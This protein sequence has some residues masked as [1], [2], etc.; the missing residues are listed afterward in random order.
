VNPRIYEKRIDAAAY[1]RQR[2]K[3]R[4][5]SMLL[6]MQLDEARIEELDLDALL[7]FAEH[8]LTNA[9][10]LWSE[11]HRQRLQCVFFPEGLQFAG[12]KFRTAVTCLAFRECRRIP[13]QKMV[14]RPQGDSQ[15]WTPG[16]WAG[17]CGGRRDV[18]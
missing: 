10:R 6:E 9:E 1:E 16:R 18:R 4:E 11:E 14:W 7:A 8:V 17:D 5:E 12:E 13:T 3:L 2:D 15:S